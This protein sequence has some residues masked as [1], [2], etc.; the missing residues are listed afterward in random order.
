L[1]KTILKR[2][3]VSKK[4]EGREGFVII[5]DYEVNGYKRRLD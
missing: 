2:K 3:P 1:K 5:F 4:K